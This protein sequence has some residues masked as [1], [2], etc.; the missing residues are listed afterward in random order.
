MATPRA[1]LRHVCA[2][3]EA[4]VA[5]LLP[6]LRGVDVQRLSGGR[7]LPDGAAPEQAAAAAPAAAAPAA[8]AVKPKADDAAVDAARLRFLE[9]KRKAGAR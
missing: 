1:Y 5:P 8:H 4:W 3:Q 6:R 9:R 2:V 7:L